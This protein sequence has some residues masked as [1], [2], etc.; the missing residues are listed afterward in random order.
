MAKSGKPTP[1][2]QPTKSK[3]APD[4][5][6]VVNYLARPAN[7]SLADPLLRK[8]FWG[9]AAFMCAA[10][11]WLSLGAGVNEDDKYQ[12]S[13]SNKLV[14]WYATMGKD[15]SALNVPDGFMHLYGGFF[16]VTTGFANKAMGLTEANPAYHD[17]RHLASA[18]LGFLAVLFTGLLAAAIAGWRA[19]LFALLL[20]F[21]SPRILGDSLINPK[22]IPFAAAYVIALYNMVCVFRDLPNPRRANIAGLVV[23]L[24]MALGIRAGGLLPFVYFGLFLGLHYLLTSGLVFRDLKKIG[25]YAAIGL[26]VVAGGYLLGILFWPYALQAPLKN[27]FYALSIFESKVTRVRSL[28]EGYNAMSDKMPWYY[29]IKWIWMT[30]PLASL[31]GFGGGLLCV[32]QLMRRY[33]PLWVFMLVFSAIFPVA[34]VI[35][36]DSVLHD[37]WRHLT[38]VYPPMVA[39]AAVFF[40]WLMQKF[41]SK[42]AFQWAIV[43]G[44][45][46][47]AADAVVWN[48]RNPRLIYTYF[49]PIEGGA[50]GAFGKYETDY[51]GTSLRLGIEWLEQQGILHENMEETVVIATSFYYC[52]KQYVAKYGDKVKIRYLKYERRCDDVWD[53]AL[54]PTRFVDGSQLAKGF[55]PPD[56]CV[57]MVAAGGA[58]ILAILKENSKGCALGTAS[59]KVND[60]QS[61]IGLLQKAVS[62]VP[63]DEVA[64]SN[65]AQAYFYA[66]SLELSKSAAEKTLSIAPDNAQANNFV[67]MYYMQK[68]DLAKAKRVFEDSY[69]R[70]ASNTGALYYIALIDAQNGEFNAALNTLNTLLKAAPTFKAAYE[71]AARIYTQM[72]DQARA[73]QILQ[74]AAQLK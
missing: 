28:F 19:G 56:N 64:W 36:K 3:P 62:E 8:I 4:P 67:G 66:D 5:R 51:W 22:D 60:Y 35:Y 55:W 34:Y 39:L 14:N 12:N 44:F 47:L 49:N 41:D 53:Y 11:L 17:V 54:Y 15:S 26:G 31:V 2:P 16:E 71:L 38:F 59:L 57:H 13:Y 18:F 63:D 70:D 61:A 52:A 7:N 74:M 30:V 58:P 21:V 43:G 20:M 48:V 10:M 33:N 27:P 6:P 50:Q 73:Q 1:K 68:N 9:A 46:L 37:G 40:G 42:K 25:R 23:G 72:G 65:L 29:P 69:R 32:L 24:G 45:V